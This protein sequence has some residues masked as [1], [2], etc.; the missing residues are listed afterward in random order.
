MSLQIKK[1]I[2]LLILIILHLV[3]LVGLQSSYSSL[4]ESLTPFNLLISAYILFSW[5][6]DFN[7]EFYWFVSIIVCAGFLVE[8]LGVKTELIFGSYQY[9]KT[10]GPKIMSVPILMG[11]NWLNLIYATGVILN[12]ISIPIY[13]KAFI[14]S[15]ILMVLDFFLEPVAIKYDFWSWKNNAIPIQNYVAWFICSYIFLLLFFFLKFKKENK[16]TLPFMIIQFIFFTTLY[17][18]I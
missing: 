2:P 18:F 11:L 7:K 5:H 14:G 9:G 1:N 4:F 17:F 6:T 15:G 10:L 12:K 16:I 3:G 8:V 13:V